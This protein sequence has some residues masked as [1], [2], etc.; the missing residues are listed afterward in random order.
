MTFRKKKAMETSVFHCFFA[1]AEECGG[2]GN[3]AVTPGGGKQG[4]FFPSRRFHNGVLHVKIKEQKY[5][6]IENCAQQ[7][8]VMNDRSSGPAYFSGR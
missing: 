6:I 8:L 4:G 1:W 2:T 3:A 5:K 7:F